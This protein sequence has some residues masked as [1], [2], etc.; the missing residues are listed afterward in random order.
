MLASVVFMGTVVCSVGFAAWLVFFVLNRVFNTTLG[1]EAE[2]RRITR[3]YLVFGAILLIASV[4]LG[5]AYAQMQPPLPSPEIRA[6]ESFNRTP[7]APGPSM[8]KT[9]VAGGIVLA[10]V[11]FLLWLGAFLLNRSFSASMRPA[12]VQNRSV[13]GQLVFG[14]LL[15][16][17]TA[18]L[19]VTYFQI[20]SLAPPS[21]PEEGHPVANALQ[22]PT[23]Q[24][25]A[26]KA[27]VEKASAIGQAGEETDTE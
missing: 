2:R 5:M 15:F 17:L 18:A 22:A 27:A 12:R 21:I 13:A 26:A 11:A 7:D 3:N 24:A 20:D 9:L 23:A 6:G 4:A 14:T 10:G 16:G 1:M 8:D 19:V 25:E